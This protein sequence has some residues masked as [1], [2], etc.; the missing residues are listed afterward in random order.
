MWQSGP[1]R[2]RNNQTVLFLFGRVPAEP[3][4]LHAR[5]LS[6]HLQQ[7][8]WTVQ[9]AG[10]SSSSAQLL[11]RRFDQPVLTLSPGPVFLPVVGTL[12]ARRL[13]AAPAVVHAWDLEAGR[14][15]RCVTGNSVRVCVAVSRLPER[16][17]AGWRA[18]VLRSAD[19]VICYSGDVA[20][21]LSKAGL[22]ADRV[23]LLPPAVDPALSVYAKEHRAAVLAALSVAGQAGPVLAVPPP[24]ESGSGHYETAWATFILRRGGIAARLIV[25][26]SRAESGR[27]V[28]FAASCREQAAI[29]PAP[30][31]LT[32]PDLLAAADIV[33]LPHGWR[34]DA[35][36]SASALACG[37]PVV[38]SSGA[39]AAS[40]PAQSMEDPLLSARTCM[41]TPDGRPLSLARTVL[42]AWQ[43]RE[44]VASLTHAAVS[45]VT[46]SC[47]PASVVQACLEI[48]GEPR[49]T[50]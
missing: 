10:L 35:V 37:K 31:D 41:V 27:L 12:F 26:G 38:L 14:A 11:G 5:T 29:A 19:C 3:A 48:Y 40:E 2:N 9:I 36:L 15:A 44:A 30:A 13:P 42:R 49:T 45:Q 28:R 47:D 43:E 32:W 16:R 46:R 22:R 39:E 24:V 33:V 18:G 34:T 4:M 7:R 1:M 23:H 8:G 20:G 21:R 25:P 6:Q 17:L 50:K